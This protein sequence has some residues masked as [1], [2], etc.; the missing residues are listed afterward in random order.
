MKRILLP[1]VLIITLI[2]C[3]QKPEGYVINGTLRGDVADGT[4]VILKKIGENNQPVA[5]DTVLTTGGT[6]TFSGKPTTPELHYIFV[7]KLP[8]YTVVVLENG[9]IEISAQKDSLNLAKIK[10]T[11]QNDIFSDYM[12]K[13]LAMSNRAMSIQKDLQKANIEK[14][15]A[16]ISALSD[17][18][19]ELQEEHKDFEIDYIKANPNGLIS[20]LLIDKAI[21]SRVVPTEDLKALY[22][23]LSP[24]IK[25][26]K[27]AENVLQR[28]SFLEEKASNGQNTTVGK[29]AP[30]FSAKSPEGK[31]IALNDIL[32]K[33]TLIDFWA[34]WCKPC[35]AENPNVL[36][37]YKKYHKK[38]L[39]IIGVSLDKDGE[40]WK[41]AILDDKLE[42]NQVSNLA[43]FNDEIAKLYNVDAIPAAFLLDENGVIIAKNLRGDALE[44]KV[45]ELLN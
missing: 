41:K 21:A 6:Y 22:E 2:A 26:N 11:I 15:D 35:R 39:N 4:Q 28:I 31:E 25:S 12:E 40:Q 16:V 36:A 20:A 29:K 30:N 10:G 27:V 38:G 42:W 44:Q 32:G 1:L 5:I 18:M 45:A 8:G 7:D 33:V 43:Y 14:N 3:N 13:S 37:V 23:G 24:E 17:E 19:K 9:E 34:A